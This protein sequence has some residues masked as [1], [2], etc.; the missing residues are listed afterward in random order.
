MLEENTKKLHAITEEI[1]FLYVR[2]RND[3]WSIVLFAG[4]VRGS[5]GASR[6]GLGLEPIQRDGSVKLPQFK[7]FTVCQR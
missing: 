2:E 4:A 1:T 3:S 6:L 7:L 5:Y